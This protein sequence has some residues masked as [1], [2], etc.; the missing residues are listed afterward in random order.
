MREYFQ[1]YFKGD[2]VIWAIIIVLSIFSVLAV[3]SSTGTLAYK[4]QGGDTTY[5]FF[6]HSMFILIGIFIV[7]I[8]HWVPYRYFSKIS[9][10]F[11]WISI[12]LLA[13][14][15]VIGT[16]LNEASRWLTLALVF[17]SKHPT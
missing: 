2:S 10:L 1:K 14:T 7:F 12:P 13:L 16:S 11:L 9:I 15:L 8:T 4:Y 3:Y 17:H 6:K 5:Y